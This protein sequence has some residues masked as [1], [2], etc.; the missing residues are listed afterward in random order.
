MEHKE[1]KMCVCE[2]ERGVKDRYK[3]TGHAMCFI[4]R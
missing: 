3:D 2:R 4:V 1:R